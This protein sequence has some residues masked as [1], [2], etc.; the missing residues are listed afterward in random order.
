MGK[1]KHFA[2]ASRLGIVVTFRSDDSHQRQLEIFSFSDQT[3]KY[4]SVVI[5][6]SDPFD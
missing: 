4:T 6:L 3:D 1:E 5:I 2:E